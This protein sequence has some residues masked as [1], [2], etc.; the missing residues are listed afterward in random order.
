MLKSGDLE[1]EIVPSL[2][3]FK[4]GK[5]RWEIMPMDDASYVVY[6][7]YLEPDFFI[8]PVV[9]AQMVQQNLLEEFTTTFIRI[10]RIAGFNAERDRNAENI[11][12]DA[13]TRTLKAPCVQSASLQ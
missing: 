7:A 10:E 11:L 3:E 12:S 2:S 1:A 5:A 9:G 13:A 4:S 6:E 8:P